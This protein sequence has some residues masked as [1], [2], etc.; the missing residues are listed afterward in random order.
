[1][2]KQQKKKFRIS[3]ISQAFDGQN[4]NLKHRIGSYTS[5]IL[6][7]FHHDIKRSINFVYLVGNINPTLENLILHKLSKLVFIKKI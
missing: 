2:T 6:T 4:S 1:M 7:A 3:H 5:E